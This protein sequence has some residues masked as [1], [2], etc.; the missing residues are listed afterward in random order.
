MPI[1]AI[2]L[3]CGAGGLSYGL[4]KAGINVR[5]GIDLDPKCE[6]PYTAN[7]GGAKFI[8]ESVTNVTGDSLSK[9][10]R[11]KSTRLLAGCA[12]CQPFSTL[13]NGTEREKSDKWPLL[14]EF[15]RLVQELT[16]DLV[17]MENV[18]N[19]QSQSISKI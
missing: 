8:R 2:D 4:R 10:Y 9:F 17:T 16:P 7:M 19:L 18:P 6:F 11:K 13:R 14:D 12:P 5:A 3:F 15:S 1:D